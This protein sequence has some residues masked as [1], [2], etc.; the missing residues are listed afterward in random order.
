MRTEGKEAPLASA[1]SLSPSQPASAPHAQP[2]KK[3][4]IQFVEEA[5]EEAIQTPVVADG[6]RFVSGWEDFMRDVR[7][8]EDEAT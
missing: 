8:E 6:K 7:D 4:P 3:E 2:L 1:S 5:V